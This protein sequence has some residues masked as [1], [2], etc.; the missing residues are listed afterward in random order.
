VPPL[1]LHSTPIVHADHTPDRWALVLHGI[2]GRGRN[3][4]AVAKQTAA[5]RPAW[6]FRLTDLRLHGDSPPGDPPHTFAAAADDVAALATTA[7]EGTVRAVIGHSFGGKVA[8]A[9]A[10]RIDTLDQIWVIDSTPAARTPGGSA[11]DMLGMVRG[12]PPRFASRAEAVAALEG[13]GLSPGVAAWMATNL[14][15]ESDTGSP[16]PSPRERGEGGYAWSLDFDALEALLRDF[17]A[18][19]LWQAVEAP[20]GQVVVHIVK[21]GESSTLDEEACARIEAAARSNGRVHLHRVSGGHWVNS[22]NPSAIVDLLATH[23][24]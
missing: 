15:A 18:T 20:P 2:Y 14:R 16:R 22:E 13:R 11:W 5:R 1:R 12:L 24:P 10:G 23:L 21:A 9:L 8:L 3:W 17:F 4:A 6:G 7:A 19:D